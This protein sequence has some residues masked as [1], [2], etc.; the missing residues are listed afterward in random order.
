MARRQTSKTETTDETAT[1]EPSATAEPA[2]PGGA[3]DGAKAA[4]TPSRPFK[5]R[6]GAAGVVWLIAVALLIG[7]G[8]YLTWPYLTGVTAPPPE[9]AGPSE[10]EQRL[11]TLESAVAA[12]GGEIAARDPAARLAAL[13]ETLDGREARMAALDERIAALETTPP[14][15]DGLADRLAAVEETLAATPAA[16]EQA[17]AAAAQRLTA[18]AGGLSSRIDALEGRLA[19]IDTLTARLGALEARLADNGGAAGP[20]ALLAVGQ[21]RAALRGAGPYGA[22]LAAVAAV[23]GDDPAAAAALAALGARA[24]TGVPTVAMLRTEFAGLASGIVRAAATPEEG[25]W[26]EQTVANLRGLVTWRCVD[27]DDMA[28]EGDE[29]I[30]AQAEALLVADDLAG[31]VK[32]V[33]TLDAG[34]AAAA[35]AAWLGRARA[36]LEAE[37]A[38]AALDAR[39]IAALGG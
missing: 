25:S 20:A 35:A 23:A 16:S 37:A 2:A 34:P 39:A 24:E 1:T 30:V 38:I 31:A 17:V 28:C 8:S 9:T 14:A 33:E 4:T 22:E 26:V 13:A 6:F 27:D 3:D 5:V 29:A 21:L 11:A 15:D 36:R 7:G 12:L 32:R 18:V 19:E 10:A